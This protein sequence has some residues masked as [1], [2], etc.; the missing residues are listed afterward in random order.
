LKT[1]TQPGQYIDFSL[2]PDERRL[3]FSRIDAHRSGSDLWMLDF[4]RG[5]EA[6]LTTAAQTDA[7]PVFAPDGQHLVF[8]SNRRGLHEL[9]E[10]RGLG[11]DDERPLFRSSGG[12]YPT[13]WATNGAVVYHERQKTRYDIYSLD[14]KRG[15]AQVLVG[16]EAEEAQGQLNKDGRLAFASDRS[17]EFDVYV[18]APGDAKSVS[19]VSVAGGSDPRWRA[20][21]REL[22]FVASDTTLM[23]VDTAGQVPGSARPLFKTRLP[24]ASSPFPS[25]MVPSRDGE[26][27]LLKVPLDL[28]ETKPLTVTT[29]WVGRLDR[30]R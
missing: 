1:V 25:G 10:F 20:D 23:A 26:R 29:D 16:T 4:D 9:F 2:S 11:G 12:I 7:S 14:M 24:P 22:F 3:A 5:I 18:S 13:D 15:T 17:G 19:R 28:P 30:E 21:G 27:F 6:K 8:R